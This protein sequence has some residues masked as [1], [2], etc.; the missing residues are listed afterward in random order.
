VSQSDRTDATAS[1]LVHRLSR[2]LKTLR[3]LLSKDIWELEHIGR[4][5]L[6]ARS[7]HFLRTLTLTFQGLRRN[8]LPLQSAALTF[9][10]MIGIG[11][12][13]A[14][15][16]M[17]SG[18]LLEQDMSDPS[19]ALQD[20]VVV[21][22]ITELITFAAPHVAVAVEPDGS[23][24]SGTQLSPQMLELI[25][26][27]SNAAQSGTVGVVG[28]LMLLVI[29]I[30]VLTSIEKSFNLLWGVAQGRKLAERI[31]T[32]WTF[33][34]LGAV[35]GTASLSLI[36]LNTFVRFAKEL[37]FGSELAVLIQFASPLASL[38]LM[39]LML[40]LFFRFIPHTQVNWKPAFS[41]AALVVV[42]LHLYK[43][44]SFLYVERVVDTNSLYGSVGIII[45]LMLGLYIFWL[46]ILLGGQ[47]TYAMQ[48]ANY[49]T[50][51]NAW[52]QISSRSRELIS[53]AVLLLVTERFR[54]CSAALHASELHKK[55]RVPS[56]ILN[57]SITR[58]CELGYLCEIQTQ[59]VETER[60][61]AYQLGRPM[62]S[63]SL[64]QFKHDFDCFGNN[65]GIEWIR[66]FHPG[67]RRYQRSVLAPH[68][69]P[70]E[71]LWITDLLP[72]G[73]D[74]AA[75]KL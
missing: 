45:I 5:T 66:D 70:S 2:Q 32:Y 26:N 75:G 61:R 17:I 56:H 42:L 69:A 12:L 43:G 23:G 40:A 11:P 30:Q 24:S 37:P 59:T 19:G 47:V 33:I 58:L 21:E 41:G 34:S 25:R 65:E 20:S 27:F 31:V 68:S 14:F 7:Y 50:N 29:G 48:N 35:L 8:Q 18:F 71:Q 36:S 15:G 39:I 53:L 6:R 72:I 9:Y 74:P 38:L 67:I 1:T 16:I 22:K 64:T 60:D 49:L 3:Q 73:K 44:L 10:T 52:Q 63:L 54:D 13:I 4:H 55:L 51:E 62:D 57:S 28:S 46:L